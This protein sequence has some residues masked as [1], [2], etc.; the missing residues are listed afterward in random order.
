MYH[1]SLLV[2]AVLVL[3]GHL[4][5]SVSVL[6]LFFQEEVKP[7]TKDQLVND[8]AEFV[9]RNVEITYISHLQNVIPMIIEVN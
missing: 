6:L 5:V 4:G 1:L 3:Y 7:I 2:Q 9:M 8:I